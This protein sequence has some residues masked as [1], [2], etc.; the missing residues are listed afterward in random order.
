MGRIGKEIYEFDEFRFDISEHL[1][2]RRNEPVPLP[3]KAFETLHL[4]IGKAGH[5]VEKDEILKTVWADAFV[6]ENNL[7]KSVSI[8]RRALG[9]KKGG[10]KFI[11]T[12]RGHGYRF[13]GDVSVFKDPATSI[14]SLSEPEKKREVVLE[15]G[16]NR[17][18]Q[19]L[20]MEAEP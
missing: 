14:L 10:R 3:A 20:A 2:L 4:L 9:E 15:A 1:L 8:L 6:E 7:D 13:V 17:A 11:E 12:V 5:L 18:P 19:I 16:L